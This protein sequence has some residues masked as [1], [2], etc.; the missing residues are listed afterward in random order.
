MRDVSPS[1]E[2]QGRESPGVLLVEMCRGRR[3]EVKTSVRMGWHGP[4]EGVW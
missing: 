3:K 2:T 4:A 1:T